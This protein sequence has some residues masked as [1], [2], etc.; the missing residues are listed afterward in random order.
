MQFIQYFLFLGGLSTVLL[1]QTNECDHCEPN[2]LFLQNGW[3]RRILSV[4]RAKPHLQCKYYVSDSAN[5]FFCIQSRRLRCFTS[6]Q[7]SLLNPA[8]ESP[9]P[10]IFCGIILQARS[11]TNADF[12]VQMKSDWNFTWLLNVQLKH[13]WINLIVCSR[14]CKSQYTVRIT[15]IYSSTTS[16]AHRLSVTFPCFPIGFW[17]LE[18]IFFYQCRNALTCDL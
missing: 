4:T 9:L 10:S 2:R 6:L 18:D 16:L 7:F 11:P 15:H 3:Q 1:F 14:H 13:Q 12:W 8:N 17:Y 5:V